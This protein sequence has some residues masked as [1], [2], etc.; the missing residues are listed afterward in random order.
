MRLRVA[1]GAVLLV[2]CSNTSLYPAK[3]QPAVRDDRLTIHGQFCTEAPQP[4]E[5]PVRILFIVDIS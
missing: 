2:A 5:F 4:A 1:L 3:Q